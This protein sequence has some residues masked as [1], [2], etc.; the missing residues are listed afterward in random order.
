VRSG[1]ILELPSDTI[2]RPGPRVVEGLE[3]LAR[4]IHPDAFPGGKSR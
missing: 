3:E 1:R 4:A 2:L